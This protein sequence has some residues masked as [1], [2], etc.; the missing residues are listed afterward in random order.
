[1]A[2]ILIIHQHASICATL[3][4]HLENIGHTTIGC[5]QKTV[6]AIELCEAG[7]PDIVFLDMSFGEGHDGTQFAQIVFGQ[8][9]V[10][11]IF[12]V[13]MVNKPMLQRAES[14][15]PTGYLM[16]PF[17]VQD[18]YTSLSNCLDTSM[19][20]MV[21][22]VL[23]DMLTDEAAMAWKKLSETSLFQV[24]THVRENLDKEITLKDLAQLVGI[25]ESSFSRRFKA[26]MGITPYQYVIQERLEAAKHMLLH[27]D[28]SLAHV[29]AA[30]GFSSQSHFTTVFK[31]LTHM[32][33][34]QYR[35]Q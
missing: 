14:L 20:R 8:S 26:S 16:Q 12:I 5:A 18:V 10:R 32:T 6:A 30:T 17:D 9:D 11:L 29:A 1:M 25:S 23:R 3:N 22:A 4:E 27:G 19:P 34:L 35:R 21:P 33:P 2:R 24:R 31:K 7:K 28:I 13:G 15:N